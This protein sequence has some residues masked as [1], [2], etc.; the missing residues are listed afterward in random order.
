MIYYKD[1]LF[2]RLFGMPPEH[3]WSRFKCLVRGHVPLTARVYG[4]TRKATHCMRCR[5]GL[6]WGDE[7]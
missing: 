6:I 2:Y 3:Y 5:R 1:T 4:T 7:L